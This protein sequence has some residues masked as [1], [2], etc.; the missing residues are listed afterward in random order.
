MKMNEER[1]Y[2]T[3]EE[4]YANER[5]GFAVLLHLEHERTK[6]LRINVFG[7]FDTKDEAVKVARKWR[8]QAKQGPEVKYR[9]RVKKVEVAT[10]WRPD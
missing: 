8:R 3:L 9:H 7:V 4:L 10:V 6:T 2:S 1:T 5:V